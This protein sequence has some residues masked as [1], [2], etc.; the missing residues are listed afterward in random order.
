[1]DIYC[2]HAT[3]TSRR[4]QWL[5]GIGVEGPG[6]SEA[7]PAKSV[8]YS[9]YSHDNPAHCGLFHVSSRGLQLFVFRYA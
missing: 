8:T 6:E 2:P 7:N 4:E 9:G 3:F 5:G 1:M